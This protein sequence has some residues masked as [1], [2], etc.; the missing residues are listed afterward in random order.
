MPRRPRS[1]PRVANTDPTLPVWVGSERLGGCGSH[2]RLG[3]TAAAPD[4]IELL[5]RSSRRSSELNAGRVDVLIQLVD[6]GIARNPLDPSNFNLLG[7][8]QYAA[9]RLPESAAAFQRL[10]GLDPEYVG[11]R[12]NYGVTLMAMGKY[13]EALAVAE[14]ESYEMTKLTALPC[15]VWTMGRRAESAAALRT[16]E[17]KYG[18]T[19]AF[20]AALNH[21]CRGEVDLAFSWLERAYQQRDGSL[22][23][24]KIHPWLQ[25]LRGDPRYNALLRKLKML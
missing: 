14:K 10:L 8:F 6:Q 1:N 21:A 7:I 23:I 4:I 13:P 9:G 12:A 20:A 18:D 17:V 5:S 11:A 22:A 24:I 2:A 16:L 3:R 15:I 19:A 25:S